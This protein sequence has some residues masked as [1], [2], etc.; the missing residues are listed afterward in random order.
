MGVAPA[1]GSHAELDNMAVP[2]TTQNHAEI[3]S[4]GMTP[5]IG[6]GIMTTILDCE[7]GPCGAIGVGVLTALGTYAYIDSGA[8]IGVLAVPIVGTAIDAAV[9][10]GDASEYRYFAT[11][12]PSSWTPQGA[13][14]A[15]LQGATFQWLAS[16]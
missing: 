4:A 6:T 10:S 5:T 12:D 8:A 7:Q 3:D 1:T 15:W 16:L 9:F 13:V 11:H 2:P 14:G